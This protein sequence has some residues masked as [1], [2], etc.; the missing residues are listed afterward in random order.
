MHAEMLDAA[1]LAGGRVGANHAQLFHCLQ[2][3]TTA[4]GTT[5]E[6]LQVIRLGSIGIRLQA[7]AEAYFEDGRD[8]LSAEQRGALNAL[9]ALHGLFIRLA[10]EWRE[11][12][13]EAEAALITPQALADAVDSVA[14][15]ATEMEKSPDAFDPEIPTTLRFVADTARKIGG[16]LKVAGLALVR[17]LGN[18]LSAT[19]R[20]LLDMARKTLTKTSDQV[21]DAVAKSLAVTVSGAIIAAAIPLSSLSQHFPDM[22][23][24]LDPLLKVVMQYFGG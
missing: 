8:P 10:P 9:L 13:E 2:R 24:W 5:L 3:Y 19:G 22:F 4:M 1:S 20:F 7:E 23:K 11:F 12:I 21:S 17:I 16:T 15:L 14:P 18:V 6:E